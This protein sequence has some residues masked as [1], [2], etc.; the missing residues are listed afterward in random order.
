MNEITAITPQVKDAK[1][2]N[3]YIDGRFYCGMT[4]ETVMKNRLKVGQVVSA[5][6]LSEI[7]LE[8]EKNTALD[9]ALYFIS[10]VKK[11]EKQVREYLQGKGY[12]EGVCEYVLA[13]MREYG[14]LDDKEYAKDY[15]GFAGTRKGERLIK[16]ELKAKGVPEED[17]D[18]ALEDLTGETQEAT[19]RRILEK[20][21]RG[22]TADRETLAKAYRYLMGKGFDYEIAKTALSKFGDT[23]E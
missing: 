18:G 5:E 6:K 20:Y 4:L 23:D 11:T 15:V 14:F 21:M 16:M 8:S 13:K 19:A 22:K 2:C 10:A 3:I 1:R 12:L 7:Q 17:I 9:K